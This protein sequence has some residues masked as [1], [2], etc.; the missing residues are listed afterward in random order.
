MKS[1]DFKPCGETRKWLSESH[2]RVQRYESSGKFN[3]SNGSQYN[4]RYVICP[5][6]GKSVSNVG[7]E[8]WKY[9]KCKSCRS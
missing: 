1:I 2:N 6:C 8:V 9:G 3:S 4:T 7:D 5:N